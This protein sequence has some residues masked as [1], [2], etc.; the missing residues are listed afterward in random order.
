MKKLVKKILLGLE[1]DKTVQS[2]LNKVSYKGDKEIN[3]DKHSKKILKTEQ[4][5]LRILF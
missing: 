5:Q 3:I 1:K 2:D 4:K